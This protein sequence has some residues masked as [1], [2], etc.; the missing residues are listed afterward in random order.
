MVQRE[1]HELDSMTDI[2]DIRSRDVAQQT[3]FWIEVTFDNL[4][5]EAII[6][7]PKSSGSSE[8]AWGER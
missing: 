5:D 1:T 6:L 8:A 2:A 4:C 7:G 3:A